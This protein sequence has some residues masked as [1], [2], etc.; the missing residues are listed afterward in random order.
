MIRPSHTISWNDGQRAN[1]HTRE[2]ELAETDLAGRVALLTGASGGIGGALGRRL[3]GAGVKTA[4]GYGRRPT[5]PSGW[6]PGRRPPG[7]TPTPGRQGSID[8][9]AAPV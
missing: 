2:A 3:I 1:K 6:W 8:R 7:R 4:F 5:R 9:P